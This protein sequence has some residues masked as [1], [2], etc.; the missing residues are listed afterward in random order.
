LVFLRC[1]STSSGHL[2][3]SNICTDAQIRTYQSFDKIRCKN[4]I[5]K[6]LSS[7]KCVKARFMFEDNQLSVISCVLTNQLQQVGD[8]LNYIIDLL[9]TRYAFVIYVAFFFFV[10]ALYKIRLMFESRGISS[11]YL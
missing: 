10:F 8:L 5:P 11:D 1:T 2:T 3:A 9:H 6:F 7:S 4:K